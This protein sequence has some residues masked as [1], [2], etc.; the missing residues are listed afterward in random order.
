MGHDERGRRRE[1][2]IATAL[3]RS[4][5]Y[6]TSD[7]GGDDYVSRRTP[8]RGQ[9][10]GRAGVPAPDRRADRVVEHLDRLTTERGEDVL[11]PSLG[12][13]QRERQRIEGEPPDVRALEGMGSQLPADRSTLE[14][15]R[16][17]RDATHPDAQP[18]EDGDQAND[19][20]LE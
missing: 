7:R 6:A 4:T 12:S 10:S 1:L 11:P 15:E 3:R 17:E 9:G 5:T 20:D 19:L 14:D 18:V 8:G 2:A 16:V 13:G